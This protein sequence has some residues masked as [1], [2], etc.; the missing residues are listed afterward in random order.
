MKKILYPLLT[1]ALLFATLLLANTGYADTTSSIELAETSSL[2][3]EM[4]YFRYDPEREPGTRVTPPASFYQT[5]VQTANIQINFVGSWPAAAQNALTYAAS[6]WESQITSTIPIVLEAEFLSTLPSGVL[7]GAGAANYYRDAGLPYSTNTWY[8]VA[9]ANAL[10]NT[11]L[12]GNTPEIYA[13]FSSTFNWYYGTDGNTPVSQTDF[14]TVALHELGH[15]LGF[16]DSTDVSGGI[17][18]WGQGSGYPFIFDRFLKN[19]SGVS[20]VDGFANNSTALATQLTSDNVYFDGPCTNSTNGTPAK[21]YA[22]NPYTPGSSIAHL[23]E[24]FNGT[25]NAL[26]TYS[27]G[28]GEAIHNPGSVTLAIFRDIGWGLAVNTAPTML[29]LPNVLLQTGTSKD[30]AIDLWLY[31]SDT[32]DEDSNLTFAITAQS[33]LTA[34]ASLDSNRYVDVNPTNSSWVGSSTV[35]VRV[36]D[37]GGLTTQKSFQIISGEISHLYLPY[38]VR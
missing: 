11:D 1:M 35:T 12:N 31:T 34:G 10:L 37:S 18:S 19:G 33:D 15:G 2:S 16:S 6:I 14:V 24:T 23:D 32:T 20:L 22:P 36:T 25:A 26:M 29:D 5:A 21:L 8:P 3:G 13:V 38:L 7:G 30:N 4:V 28:S 27:L 9:L 17:G